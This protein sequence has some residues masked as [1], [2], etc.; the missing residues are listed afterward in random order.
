MY[1]LPLCPQAETLDSH[2]Q[3]GGQG[4]GGGLPARQGG[5]Q[6]HG[7]SGLLGSVLHSGKLRGRSCTVLKKNKF[8]LNNTAD[9]R[10]KCILIKELLYFSMI[11]S[12]ILLSHLCLVLQK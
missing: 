4:G 6:G 5:T 3:G 12:R 2:G 10:S 11:V 9:L 8:V 1:V 7:L